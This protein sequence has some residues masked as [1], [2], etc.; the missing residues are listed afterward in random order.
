MRGAAALTAVHVCLRYVREDPNPRPTRAAHA[1]P[2][3]ALLFALGSSWG[4]MASEPVVS[5]EVV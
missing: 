4:A 1:R 5:R 2:A 3:A